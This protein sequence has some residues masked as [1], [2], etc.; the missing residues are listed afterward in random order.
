M[1]SRIS[2][3]SCTLREAENIT[4][5]VLGVVQDG[6]TGPCEG[7][8]AS[9]ETR[10]GEGGDFFRIVRD[11]CVTAWRSCWDA[12]PGRLSPMPPWKAWLRFAKIA[13]PTADSRP[14]NLRDIPDPHGRIR[15]RR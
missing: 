9:L 14:L 7:L 8:R 13:L 10:A 15:H 4:G 2:T 12:G 3:R 11:K 5:L 1:S 6:E